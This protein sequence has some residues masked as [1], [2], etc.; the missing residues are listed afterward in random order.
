MSVIQN[1]IAL[2]RFGLGYNQTDSAQMVQAGPGT[3][4]GAQMN[5]SN[6]A[7]FNSGLPA[8]PQL[9][10]QVNQLRQDKGDTDAR[11]DDAKGMR[12]EVMQGLYARFANSVTTPN[13][14][15]ERMA[16]FWSNHFTVSMVAKPMIAPVMLDFENNAIR[17]NIFGKFEDML[18]ASMHHPAMLLYLDN[19]QSIGPN[20]PAGER[21]G[22]GLNENLARELMELHT[23][24]VDA[25][26]TQA[27]VTE[28]AKIITGWS[29]AGP[30]MGGDG[31]FLYNDRIH[32][33]GPHTVMGKTYDQ[34]GEQ[35]GLAALHDL[36]T[37]PATAHHIAM[38][39]AIHFIADDPPQSAVAE[40]ASSFQQSGGDLTTVY[41]TLA[42]LP[43]VWAEPIPKVKTPYE[44]VVSTFRLLAIPPDALPFPRVYQMLVLM[45]QKP[46]GAL[47][48][49]GWSDKAADWL[50]P[51]TLMNRIEWCHALA[52]KIPSG[53]EQSPTDLAMAAIG[54]VAHPETLKWIERAPSPADGYALVLASAE[55]QRR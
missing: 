6:A 16:L 40:L 13:P 2:N 43:E 7:V 35:Q 19:A 22:K 24:G 26:Y 29:I 34:Q 25:G 47:S 50:S 36:A 18:L 15:A 12:D 37:H 51:N 17:P 46:F 32:E 10:A 33:P 38:K 52:Q 41:R 45:D 31:G 4:L 42:S 8:L 21:R 30:K 27:D 44:M 49:A 1:F 54:P 28:M 53:S 23:L 9:M 20:S 11:K 55:F 3:W 14:F 39:L 48:P 5:R